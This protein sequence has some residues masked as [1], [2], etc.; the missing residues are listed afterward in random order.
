MQEE[1]R[2]SEKSQKL[3]QLAKPSRDIAGQAE[4]PLEK[5]D[6]V[7]IPMPPPEDAE[8]APADYEDAKDDF[9]RKMQQED[10]RAKTKDGAD[11]LLEAYAKENLVWLYEI[12]TMGGMPREDFIAK[13]K[14]KMAESGMIGPQAGPEAPNNPALAALGKEIDKRYKK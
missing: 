9:K 5:E 4:L 10:I 7:D 12:Y 14:E 13:V 6:D 11:V 1:R 3:S 8:T 2:F